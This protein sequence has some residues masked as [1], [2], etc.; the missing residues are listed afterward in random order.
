MN[1]EFNFSVEYILAIV[2]GVI[3]L[4]QPKLLNYIIAIFFIGMGV[5]GL[6]NLTLSDLIIY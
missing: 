3:I 2:T 4:I 6:L 5:L 1:V